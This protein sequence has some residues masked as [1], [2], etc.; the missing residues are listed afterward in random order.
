MNVNRCDSRQQ[1]GMTEPLLEMLSHPKALK[2]K[3]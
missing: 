1:I 3:T 2:L